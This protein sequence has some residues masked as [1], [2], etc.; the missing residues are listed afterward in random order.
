MIEQTMPVQQLNEYDF[1]AALDCIES[2]DPE[3][4]RAGVARLEKIGGNRSFQVA[5]VLVGDADPVVASIARR[6]CSSQTRSGLLWRG[7]QMPVRAAEKLVIINGWQLLDEIVFICRRNLSELAYVSFLASIPKLLLVFI[8]FAGPYV[9]SDF[10]EYAVASVFIALLFAHQLLWRPMAWLAIGKA[11]VGGFPDRMSRQQARAIRIRELY[12]AMFL[13]NLVPALAFS[14]L[15]GYGLNMYIGYFKPFE[16]FWPLVLCWLIIWEPY[17]LANPM[18]LLRGTFRSAVDGIF[19]RFSSKHY[20]LKKN[21]FFIMILT[22]FYLMLFSSSIAFCSFV[23]MSLQP[24]GLKIPQEIWYL[25]LLI[26]A[27]CLLDPFVIGYRIL[28]AR[29]NLGADE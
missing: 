2:P 12:F 13:A 9:F 21:L 7:M 29:L 3:T 27:D 5:S 6:I 11:F 19:L 16:L 8:L 1:A 26:S 28:I 24:T 4:R 15:L 14:A 10:H 18:V 20:F 17:V 25:A 22:V 23:G